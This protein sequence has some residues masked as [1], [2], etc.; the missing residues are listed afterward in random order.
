M[1]ARRRLAL[2][3]GWQLL[4]PP[5]RVAARRA[6]RVGAARKL[7][8]EGID[9]ALGCR[10]IDVRAA[11]LPPDTSAGGGEALDVVPGALS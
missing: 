6:A 8:S 3:G 11:P 10:S 5:P 2:R 1:P 7:G 4:L 9:S